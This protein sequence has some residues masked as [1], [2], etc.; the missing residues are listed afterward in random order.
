MSIREYPPGSPFPGRI[1]RTVET[2]SPAWPAPRR[3]RPGAPNVL[4]IVLD[5]TGFGQLGC[6]GAPIRTPNIDRLAAGGLLYNRMHTTAICSST[7]SCVLT[8]RNHHANHLGSVADVATGYPGYD[9]FVPFEHGFLSEILLLHGYN[10]YM[11]GKWHLTPFTELSAAGPYDRWPLGRGF[12]RFYGFLEGETNQY[13]PELVYDNHRVAPPR[14]P[15]EGYHLTEDL[16][17]RAIAFV[18]DA[19]QIAPDKPFFLYLAP[20]A[21][22]APHQVPRR[23]ADAYAG[24]FDDGWE[25]YRRRVF[26]RQKAL[27]VIPPSTELPPLDPDVP[28]WDA[29]SADE[30]RLY[31]RMMEV[32]AGFLEHTDH[33]I[34][35]LL[36][37]LETIGALDDT[38]IMLLS[39]NGASPEGGVTGSVQENRFF[40]MV[41]ESLEHNLACIAELGGPE[42]LNHYP[43]GWAWAGDTPFRRWKRETYRGGTSDPFIVH[44][45]AGIRARGEVRQP[46]VH[47]ID[48][49]PTVLEALGIEPPAQIRGVPQAPMHGVSFAHT[50]DDPDAPSR[51]RV[52]Y[53]E[54]LGHRSMYVDGWHAVC[55]WPGP[56]F[57][58][59]GALGTPLTEQ[60][61]GELDASGWELYHVDEDF[62]Q[63]HDLADRRR[64]KLMELVTAWYVEAGKYDVLPLDARLQQRLAEERPS[65]GVETDR[66]V[67]YPGTQPVPASAAARVLNRL[68]T[69]SAVVELPDD[70][71]EG[72]L[73]A[74][75]GIG[76]G[77]ALYVQERRLRYV[78]N[79]VGAQTFSIVADEDLT[80]GRHVLAMQFTPT[81][82]ARGE[83]GRGAPGRVDLYVDGER[84][85]GGDLPVTIPFRLGGGLSVGADLDSPV[86]R[87]YAAPFPFRGRLE[88]VI[89]DVSG[90]LLVNHEAELRA[91]LARD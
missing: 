5:D 31:A 77:F 79:Y 67:Y 34:G 10:T 74:H 87:L 12:Q 14:T 86:T 83:E 40:N 29:L 41:P 84:V 9:G 80:P 32:Y 71:A 16:V 23:W 49:V 2:S 57:V 76:G 1:G 64:S 72:V 70:R 61:L 56:S 59:G 45:P 8:G 36:G 25:A 68:H 19:K 89:Y 24:A 75:G 54:M 58:E 39:D 81:G 17:D 65:V 48:M 62:A 50:F 88:R 26:A 18:A 91:A 55:P 66:Y 82:E 13:W 60:R 37:F 21:T 53:F 44:W 11:V 47:V 28:R 33:E 6:Y 85:G 42:L 52:Q 22:H 35:R 73:V 78:Y 63:A 27:G 7:R 20:G 30:R 46:F 90:R 38:L 43:W 69:I 4:F 3:A 15:E 51:H